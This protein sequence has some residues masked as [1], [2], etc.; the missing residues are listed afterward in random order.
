MNEVDK[1]QLE[2]RYIGR[3]YSQGA[4]PA[5][6]GE[7]K[8]RQNY[9]FHFLLDAPQFEASDSILDVGCGY[10]D[11]FAFLRDRGWRG[12]YVGI[13]IVPALIE[14]GHSKYPGADLRVLDIE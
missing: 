8:R 4:V 6:L 14:A 1:K 7:P 2:S 11:L 10:G 3:L 9:Y 5:A 13:D 12:R